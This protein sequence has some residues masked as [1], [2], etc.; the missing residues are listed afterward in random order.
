M[1]K[2][3]I[4]KFCKELKES[5]TKIINWKKKEMDPLTDREKKY[6]KNQK[7]CYICN[8]RFCYNQFVIFNP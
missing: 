8:K 7:T 4:K 2:D 5:G 3:C 1:G 6:Y